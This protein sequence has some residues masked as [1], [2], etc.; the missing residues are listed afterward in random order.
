MKAI[1]K[2]SVAS[3]LKLMINAAWYLQ[4]AIFCGVL[5]MFVY[6]F[7]Q[8]EY[9]GSDVPVK[10][11]DYPMITGIAATSPNVQDTYLTINAGMLHVEQRINW[12][13]MAAML[14]Y[15]FVFAALCLSIT[16]LLRKIFATLTTPQPFDPQNASRLRRI[17]FLVMLF[18]P[19]ELCN[20]VYMHTVIG[21]NFS[22][23]KSNSCCNS[24]STSRSS[25]W[26]RCCWS[27]RRCSGSGRN[28]AKK[29]N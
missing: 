14:A 25:S 12:P 5:I 28:C 23:E 6:I 29:T 18:S 20:D 3:V 17:A 16:Y 4:F 11:Q 24:K 13:L 8:K 9:I 15:L 7:T 1:G 2:R 27:L 26:G 21:N 19:L 22:R 10:I